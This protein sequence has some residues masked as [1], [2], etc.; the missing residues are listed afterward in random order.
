[1]QDEVHQAGLRLRVRIDGEGALQACLELREILFL[2]TDRLGKSHKGPGLRVVGQ[3]H[4]PF[5]MFARAFCRNTGRAGARHFIGDEKTVKRAVIKIFIQFKGAVHERFH[6]RDFAN[7]RRRIF[8]KRDGGRPGRA[9]PV[10][11]W[12]ILW[13]QGL[14]RLPRLGREA[15]GQAG[16][17]D[18]KTAQPVIPG[19]QVE[20]FGALPQ[21]GGAGVIGV[22]D[23]VSLL[24]HKGIGEL[25][26]AL[27]GSQ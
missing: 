13:S 10:E 2:H 9:G 15:G 27:G 6:L 17:V 18:L 1:M 22:L 16:V 23:F 14:N 5:E 11:Q 24:L 8:G 3:G 26:E 25:R 19:A 20:A 7:Q 12:H 4:R 21:G